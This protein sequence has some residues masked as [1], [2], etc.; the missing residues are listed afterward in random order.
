MDFQGLSEHLLQYSGDIVS[1]LLPGGRLEG[2]EW[3]CADLKG[4]RG[5]S[6]RVNIKTGRWAEF[7]GDERGNDLISLYSAVH[8]KT[9]SQSFHDLSKKYN[10]ECDH[11]FY[12]FKHGYPSKTWNYHNKSGAVILTV[13]RYDTKPK[14]TFCPW[15]PDGTMRYLSEPRP[16]YNLHILTAR[17]N[18]P[19]L[20]VEGEKSAEAASI[21]TGGRYICTT[22]PGGS[23]ASHKAD[24][25][26][27]SGRNILI[28]PDA[29]KPGIEAA[30][31]IAQTLR[32]IAKQIKILNVSGQ[33][34]GWD[35]A[36]SGFDFDQF[37]EWA[38]PRANAITV[39]AS[40]NQVTAVAQSV[41]GPA[42]AAVQVN[43]CNTDES[44]DVSGSTIV[45]WEQL[46]LALSQ[47]GNPITNM[48]NV[49]RIFEGEP[50]LINTVWL[51]KFYQRI[52]TENGRPWTDGDTLAMCFKIQRKYGISRISPETVFDAV[53]VY[54]AQRQRNEPRDWMESLKWDGKHRIDTFFH[55]YMGSELTPYTISASKNFWVAIAARTYDPGCQMDNCIVL[56]GLQGIRKSSS[57][58]IIGGKWYT[59]AG[60]NVLS[61][62]FYEILQGKLIIEV[63]ELDG[64]S[65]AEV[66][67][68][69]KVVTNPI[70][71]FRVSYGKLAEDHPRQCI[72]VA[73]TN[74]EMPLKDHTGGRRF[75]PIEVNHVDTELIT[76]DREQLF[77]EA[78]HEYKNG[79]KWYIM[80]EDETKK[81][82]EDNR[83]ADE[84]ENVINELLS[85]KPEVTVPEVAALLKIGIDKLDKAHQM[86]IARCLSVCGYKRIT[87]CRMNKTHKVWILPLKGGN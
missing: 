57:L 7:A 64:F 16:L 12:H 44:I 82:Q 22:W 41:A 48:D 79:S 69:K 68:I 84:W 5:D 19:V 9:Q 20:I 33:P 77:A 72:F 78:V 87:V 65:R 18:D 71:R 51:D 61:K 3:C 85:G 37:I 14:K 2:S 36:D 23:N 83:Q 80:P 43:V 74:E 67:T 39:A 63:A 10:F 30:D 31:R 55:T 52:L 35:A 28:W 24:W 54:A 11:S 86:R 27:L 6:C 42:I 59:V 73:T 29:D 76:S 49:I 53:C 70:D 15:Q 25:Y 50:S 13:A 8:G 58:R 75:W 34:D 17:P 60:D 46:G 4:G 45:L 32:P 81:I 56:K 62:D 40:V 1:N 21:I 47:Q 26:V 38:K 66:N